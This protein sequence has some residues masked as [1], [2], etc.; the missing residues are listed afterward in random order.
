MTVITESAF[1]RSAFIFAL[2]LLMAACGDS[3]GSGPT[4]PPLAA[5]YALTYQSPATY[6]VDVAIDRLSP[7]VIGSV[8]SYTVSPALPAGLALDPATGRITGTPTVATPQATYQ[9]TATN[10][11]GA[12]SFDLLIEVQDAVVSTLG[13]A[14][15]RIVSAGTSIAITVVIQP[16]NFSFTPPLHVR[17]NDP[18]GFVNEAVAVTDN[19]D[20]TY[21]LTITTGATASPGVFAGPLLL[22]L[23]QDAACSTRQIAPNYRM[24]FALSVMSPDSEWPGDT[25]SALEAWEDVADWETFQ[26]NTAHTGY[27]PAPI[28]V[29]RLSPRWQATLSNLPSSIGTVATADGRVFTSSARTATVLAREE[30]DGSEVWQR[31]FTDLQFPSANAP[32]VNNGTVYIVAGQ[33]DSVTMYALD[34]ADGSL[35]FAAPMDS[36]WEYYLPPAVGP[37]GVYTNSGRF[38]GLYG[39]SL[40]GQQLFFANMP[41]TT[42]WTPAIDESGMYTYVGGLLSRR[43]PLTGNVIDSIDS[44]NSDERGAPVLG[45]P[46]SVFTND[47]SSLS[48]THNGA[49]GNMLNNFDMDAHALRWQVFGAYTTAVAYHDGEVVAANHQPLRLEARAENDGALLWS[50]V[51]P[52][53]G[54]TAFISNVVLTPQLAFV[55]T[56]RSVYAV[57]RTSHKAVWSYPAS[58]QLAIS[59]N[60]ILYIETDSRLIAINLK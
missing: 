8:A 34:A 18:S 56:N 6:L 51:P 50:W 26:G 60:G 19:T 33:Q 20:G 53:G 3:D 59:R 58:G 2:G 10:S 40:T 13:S 31:A 43:D 38:G 12:S 21:S 28:D 4:V 37:Y 55:S 1:L 27:V 39:F 57:D 45:A 35:S 44:A 46:G 11:S 29:N 47:F 24:P 41:Q 42:G 48:S 5:P 9:V 32:S 14:P 15:S 36:Q 30:F 22:D 23:C 25:L 52:H 49:W 7:R 17:A 16:D 54:D